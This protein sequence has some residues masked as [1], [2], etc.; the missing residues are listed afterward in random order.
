M[1]KSIPTTLYKINGERYLE[2]RETLDDDTNEVSMFH[3]HEHKAPTLIFFRR[4][5][6]N[7]DLWASIT[8]CD[9][10]IRNLK[11]CELRSKVSQML[12]LVGL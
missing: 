10:L 11:Q 5:L 4:G 6:D 9:D 12:P 7:Y 2:V 8:Y 1:S 3:I